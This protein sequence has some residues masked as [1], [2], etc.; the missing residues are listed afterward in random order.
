MSAGH[1]QDLEQLGKDLVLL[2]SVAD[3]VNAFVERWLA[4]RPDVISPTEETI[5]NVVAECSDLALP[6]RNDLRSFE[7]WLES[8]EEW[9]HAQLLAE[10]LLRRYCAHIQVVPSRAAVPPPPGP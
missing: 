8:E 7:T 3:H 6:A 1:R 2:I 5:L 10:E 4:D 9:T